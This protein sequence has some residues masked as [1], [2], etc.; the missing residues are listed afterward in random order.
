MEISSANS[1]AALF[2][3]FATKV[4]DLDEKHEILK[5][6]MLLL[7]QSFIKQEDRVSKEISFLRDDIREI[8]IELEKIKEGVQHIIKEADGFARKEEI[9]TIERYVKI[10]D[11]L[12]MVN[13]DDVKRMIEEAIKKRK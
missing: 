10:W 12:K 2:A 3:D 7:S 1:A 4:K 9:Q 6:K 13:E 11:P 8:M 5:E